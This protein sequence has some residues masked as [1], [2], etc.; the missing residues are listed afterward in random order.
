MAIR[1]RKPVYI[2]DSISARLTID[3]V[4]EQPAAPVGRVG[5]TLQIINNAIDAVA[6]E[7][8]VDYAVRRKS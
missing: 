5:A 8:H 3:E 1:Y 7:V 2:G 6:I 4:D